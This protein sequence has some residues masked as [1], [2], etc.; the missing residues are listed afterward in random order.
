[1]ELNSEICMVVV[2]KDTLFSREERKPTRW[3]EREIER[4]RP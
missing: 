4:D 2:H 1:V 3:I